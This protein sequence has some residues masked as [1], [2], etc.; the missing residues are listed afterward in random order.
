M[1]TEWFLTHHL[2]GNLVKLAQ[3]HGFIGL[4]MG[5]VGQLID[6]MSCRHLFHHAL[7]GPLHTLLSIEHVK[8]IE[9]VYHIVLKID[10]EPTWFRFF[11]QTR[12]VGCVLYTTLLKDLAVE[13]EIGHVSQTSLLLLLQC[14]KK[15]K[16]D[17]LMPVVQ[18][19][20]LHC[21]QVFDH[22]LEKGWVGDQDGKNK[23][24]SIKEFVDF[25]HQIEQQNVGLDI[26]TLMEQECWS[27]WFTRCT[28]LVEPDRVASLLFYLGRVLEYCPKLSVDKIFRT[29]QSNELTLL[30]LYLVKL[31]GMPRVCHATIVF[32]DRLFKTCPSL[33]DS[34]VQGH[35]T[36]DQVNQLSNVYLNLVPFEEY[37]S[38]DVYL[39]EALISNQSFRVNVESIQ[40][41][42]EMA[43]NDM[44]DLLENH[45]FKRLLELVND[46][47]E[48]DPLMNLD[49]CGLLSTLIQS[50]RFIAWFL[51]DPLHDT[52]Y[53]RLKKLDAQKN[54]FQTILPDYSTRLEQ[55][56]RQ[57]VK[58]V[59]SR[60][61]SN[62]VL[63]NEFKKQL[64]SLLV[65]RR[66]FQV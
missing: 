59:S 15:N 42:N 3:T 66:P 27:P 17:D 63:L 47:F 8:R 34:L 58:E 13:G 20:A 21:S 36:P 44:G 40:E 12:P 54:M 60:T 4:V 10:Q 19:L 64:F 39:T 41:K 25:S 26:S 65:M 30:D 49:L 5:Y 28:T 33:L 57:G 31:Y 37:D 29:V 61:L 52:L 24:A 7:V 51:L 32:L 6:F 48:N 50:R 9:L 2:L 22:L 14:I 62:S 46:W 1:C 35:A 23:F 53:P 11:Y 56:R 55:V 38:L 45:F 43:Q 18:G 16:R